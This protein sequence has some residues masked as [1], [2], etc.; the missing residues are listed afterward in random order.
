MATRKRLLPARPGFLDGAP[1]AAAPILPRAPIAQVAGDTAT[2]AAFEEVAGDLGRARDE[3]RLVLRL[4]RAAIRTDHLIRDRVAVD[5]DALDALKQSLSSRGQQAPVEVAALGGG[6]YGL[7]SGWRRLRALEELSRETGEPGFDTVLA[8][9]RRPA[10]QA[11]AYLAMVEENEIRADLSFYERARI[12]LKA[13]EAG[14]YDSDKQ[15]LQSLFPAVSYSRRSKIKSFL[16]LVAA[17]DAVLRHPARIGERMGLALSKAL[18]A[19]PALA[20]RL[21]A[22]LAALDPATPE[23]EAAALRRALTAPRAP[24]GP[25][26][27]APDKAVARTEAPAAPDRASDTEPPEFETVVS[28]VQMAR[29]RGEVIL[30]GTRLTP[31]FIA[32]LEGWLKAQD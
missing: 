4:E 27:A 15:A 11:E 26:A 29:S 10:D 24:G 1:G 19:D 17:F 28:G 21:A 9:V 16:P 18:E 20:D 6:A 2:A 12:V 7:I 30:R 5:R 3:G 14:V 8:L 25:D 31:A 23:A 13:V 22:E 32:R